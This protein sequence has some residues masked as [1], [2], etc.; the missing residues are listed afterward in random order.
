MKKA[1]TLFVI[2]GL[3]AV[4]GYAG[5]SFRLS[6][7]AVNKSTLIDYNST[8]NVILNGSDNA[9]YLY[10]VIIAS[11]SAGTLSIYDRSGSTTSNKIG[12][13]DISSKGQYDYN[14]LLSSGI[15]IQS[16]SVDSEITITYK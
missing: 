9:E 8:N 16:D 5:Q 11:S 13:I 15:T 3:T 6:N 10:S 4:Q 7:Y 12:Y 2:L 14:V 1:L